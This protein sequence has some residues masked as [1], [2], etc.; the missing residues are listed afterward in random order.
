MY[1][2]GMGYSHAVPWPVVVPNQ[3]ND[4]GLSFND[5]LESLNPEPLHLDVDDGMGVILVTQEDDRIDF[6]L[7][8]D[9][10]DESNQVAA[11]LE[12]IWLRMNIANQ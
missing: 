12:V 8:T 11:V 1:L 6:S 3:S 7:A 9:P 10:H 4:R 5:L 2:H